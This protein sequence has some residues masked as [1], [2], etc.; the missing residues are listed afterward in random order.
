MPHLKC[1]GFIFILSLLCVAGA[2]ASE[3]TG[4]IST[5]PDELQNNQDDGQA[6]EQVQEDE[7]AGPLP[8][9]SEEPDNVPSGGSAPIFFQ[10]TA[11]QDKTEQTGKDDIDENQDNQD[12]K[13]S[14][15]EKENIKIL[16]ISYYQDG[17]LLRGSDYKIYI[18]QN[19]AKKYIVSLQELKKYAGQLI[20]D[21]SDE[22]L[23][24]YQI[25]KHSDN[26]LIRE[27]GTYKIYVIQ[28]NRKKHILSIEEL[29]ANYRGQE[30]FNISN[31]EIMLYPIF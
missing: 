14:D 28:N 18:I 10:D 22:C 2:S 13:D 5:N 21:V 29:R 4:R 12:N 16:G 8:Q 6:D 11:K 17:S 30:I 26:E 7:S 15:K 19:Q 1:A 25:K 23:A 20:Y 31:E 24:Q 27:K 3:I 9:V